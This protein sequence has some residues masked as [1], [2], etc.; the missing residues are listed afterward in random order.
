[1]NRRKSEHVVIKSLPVDCAGCHA[2]IH[3]G[4]FIQQNHEQTFCYKC[5]SP[6]DWHELTFDHNR[7]SRFLL[8]GAHQMVECTGC[9]KLL[10]TPEGISYIKYKPLSIECVDCHGAGLDKKK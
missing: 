9:H 10:Q 2:D 8:E 4:Q 3:L 7:D 5:H 1:M 6:A